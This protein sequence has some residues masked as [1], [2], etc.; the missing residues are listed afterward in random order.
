MSFDPTV[1]RDH[2]LRGLHITGQKSATST[3]PRGY[4]LRVDGR[5]LVRSDLRVCGDIVTKGTISTAGSTPIKA[6]DLGET[7]LVITKPGNYHLAE[8][9]VF[10]PPFADSN[11]DTVVFAAISIQSPD[12]CLNFGCYTLSLAIP[13]DPSTQMPFCTGVLFGFDGS[14]NIFLQNGDPDP[15]FFDNPRQCQNITIHGCV[16][17][18]KDFSLGGISTTVGPVFPRPPVDCSNLH[19]Y[20]MRIVNTGAL[21]QRDIRPI[22]FPAFGGGFEYRP[23]F[24]I[25]PIGLNINGGD[26][27]GGGSVFPSGVVLS[28]VTV[29]DSYHRGAVFASLKSATV[30]DCHFDETYANDPGRFIP[31]APGSLEPAA[32]IPG[33]PTSVSYSG[34]TA[35]GMTITSVDAVSF[36]RCTFNGTRINARPVTGET[37]GTK[38][39]VLPSGTSPTTGQEDFSMTVPAAASGLVVAFGF[40][41]G[42]HFDE[43]DFLDTVCLFAAPVGDNTVMP[44]PN[45]AQVSSCVIQDTLATTMSKCIFGQLGGIGIIT[46]FFASGCDLLTMEDCQL[47][48]ILNLAQVTKPAPLVTYSGDPLVGYYILVCSRFTMERCTAINMRS[49]AP[50]SNFQKCHGLYIPVPRNDDGQSDF[51]IRDCVFESVECLNGCGLVNGLG[52]WQ[53]DVAAAEGG[54]PNKSK[55]ITV[56]RCK[57]SG[58]RNI[59]YTAT[60]NA[61]SPTETYPKYSVVQLK[62]FPTVTSNV[63]IPLSQPN[64][65]SDMGNINAVTLE[66][67]STLFYPPGTF[68]ATSVL[69]LGAEVNGQPDGALLNVIATT[70]NTFTV[71]WT[72]ITLS[73]AEATS[74][75]IF[76]GPLA[77]PPDEYPTSGINYIAAEEDAMG[78]PGGPYLDPTPLLWGN[79][80]A[81]NAFVDAATTGVAQLTD[82]GNISVI[83][84]QGVANGL[85][86]FNFGSG[87]TS[88]LFKDCEASNNVGA[89]EKALPT[90]LTPLAGPT[91]FY[92]AGLTAQPFFTVDSSTIFDSCTSNDNEHGFLIRDCTGFTLKDNT[93]VNNRV[94]GFTDTGL[95]GTTDAPN[96]STSAWWNNKAFNNGN[97]LVHVGS[98]ANYNVFAT[99]NALVGNP[100]P[101]LEVEQSSSSMVAT[102]PATYFPGQ[103]NH[104]VIP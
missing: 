59:G 3:N 92:S 14:E 52:L 26:Y 90:F 60:D 17:T 51:V 65:S 98:D 96:Q 12:V 100:I 72:G 18:I 76:A 39:N 73:G 88:T 104:S 20:G 30:V 80:F 34:V 5:A 40:S 13:D 29:T 35:W 86:S 94:A 8:D 79:V 25:E 67:D 84:E 89:A 97:T 68:P 70:G 32:P 44:G 91:T 66:V 99:G 1:K 23:I 28:N 56:E 46:G 61:W 78:I 95:F 58:Q 11:T 41:T 71:Y 101:I 10:A 83:I 75:N 21:M 82:F 49:T 37:I 63:S 36:K 55:A 69:S 16:G 24:P 50:M 77:A 93:A 4:D 43:C 81:G 102:F 6:S 53:F 87:T 45:V 2:T 38:W 64:N 62:N 15:E 54:T 9:I 74:A 57:A 48:S 19:I 42:L 27:P 33:D 103:H 85:G 22:L 7:G 31:S 47:T